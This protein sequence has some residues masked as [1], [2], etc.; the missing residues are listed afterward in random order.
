M[1]DCNVQCSNGSLRSDELEP[2]LNECA[3]DTL[4]ISNCRLDSAAFATLRAQAHPDIRLSL[5]DVSGTLDLSGTQLR[6]LVLVRSSLDRIDLHD[7]TLDRVRIA[8]STDAMPDAYLEGTPP[9]AR[10]TITTVSARGCH[11]RTFALLAT[12]VINEADFQHARIDDALDLSW[13]QA[14]KGLSLRFSD[15]VHVEAARLVTKPALDMFGARASQ[16]SL[17][18]ADL[19][20]LN[21]ET[22][23][24]ERVLS[25]RRTSIAGPLDG[26]WLS[27]GTIVFDSASMRDVVDLGY[28]HL[29]LLE[30]GGIGKAS[31]HVEGLHVDSIGGD[32]AGLSVKL[33]GGGDEAGF[34]SIEAALRNSG[35]SGEANA[36]AFE[37]SRL[38]AIVSGKLPWQGGLGLI[39]LLALFVFVAARCCWRST[40]R[41]RKL[42]H[43]LL[44]ALDIVLPSFVDI[45]ALSAWTNYDDGAKKDVEI[46]FAGSPRTQAF[47]LRILGTMAF[48][49][50]LLYVTSLRA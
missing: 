21:V 13:T 1:P 2:K 16:V 27:A 33:I 3:H 26:Y 6:D 24:V 31:L 18:Y 46:D 37:G 19:G 22:A 11:A 28:A 23:S 25:L 44:C 9:P 49:Y 15:V 47:V 34:H 12:H 45:G 8:P 4:T 20:G 14:D 40:K 35:R 29:G 7:A 48:T 41:D 32:L 38:S 43:V 50:L 5:S 10:I 39:A 30:L 17:A 42:P 36:I